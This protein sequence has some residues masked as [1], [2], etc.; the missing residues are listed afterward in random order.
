[1]FTM[2]SLIAQQNPDHFWIVL[3]LMI[4]SCILGFWKMEIQADLTC[5]GTK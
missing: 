2:M 5:D 4:F 3:A 1:M